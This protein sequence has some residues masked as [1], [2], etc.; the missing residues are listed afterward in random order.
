VSPLA[1]HQ[2]RPVP[3]LWPGPLPCVVG[4]SGPDCPVVDARPCG[5]K[6]VGGRTPRGGGPLGLSCSP[7]GGT[8]SLIPPRA[9]APRGGR[10]CQNLGEIPRCAPAGDGR[11]SP[12]CPV[13]ANFTHG[14]VVL[15][16]CLYPLSF[17]AF[18][19]YF[20]FALLTHPLLRVE[21]SYQYSA[22]HKTFTPLFASLPLVNIIFIVR[23]LFI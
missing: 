8:H 7:D 17:P 4:P 3:P 1:E 11:S 22:S 6:R 5:Q 9:L 21:K 18:V 10:A 2:G 23:E 13:G 20:L 15:D 12:A 14:I 19:Y 16:S